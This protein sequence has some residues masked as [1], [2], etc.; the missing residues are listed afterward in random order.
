[1]ASEPVVRLRINLRVRGDSKGVTTSSQA[2]HKLSAI[3]T[4]DPCGGTNNSNH[5]AKRMKTY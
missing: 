4:A 1:M 3:R 2:G 5:T